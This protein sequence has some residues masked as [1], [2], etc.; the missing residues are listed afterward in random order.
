M[1][2]INNEREQKN[3]TYKANLV[4]LRNFVMIEWEQDGTIHPTISQRFGFFVPG[5]A[6]EVLTLR[7]TELYKQDW[8]G[9]RK[10]DE[11]G[12]LKMYTVPGRHMSL[13]MSWMANVIIA[14]YINQT[15]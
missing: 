4:R 8:L 7:Q 15:L 5:Q 2:D 1:A 14:K 13:D 3:E 10:L 11:D 12:K 9:L 6:K